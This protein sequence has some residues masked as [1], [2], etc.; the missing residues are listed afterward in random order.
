[1]KLIVATH[2]RHK[3]D[4]FRELMDQLD[5][6]VDMLPNGLPD[7]PEDGDTF[8][9]NA[10]QKAV[11]Y[12]RYVDDIVVSDDSGL[13]VPLLDGEPGIYSARYAGVHGDDAA[14]NAKLIGR[15]HEKG[16]RF[17]PARFVCA[18]SV[19]RTGKVLCSVEGHVDGTVY[20][21]PKGANGFGYDPLFEPTGQPLR[22][23][24]MA[25]H[26]KAQYSHRAAAVRLLA[27]SLRELLR[28]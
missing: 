12:S 7:A 20:D 18:L 25:S 11:F 2:N 4:E 1:M 14:N 17:A 13:Q 26:E 6:D 5:L 28:I 27:G 23:A 3:V 24:E 22:F 9:E 21:I 15:L 8:L 19:C 16:V 10:E